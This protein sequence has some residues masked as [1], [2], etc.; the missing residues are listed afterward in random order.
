MADLCSVRVSG[1][2]WWMD[3]WMDEVQCST[4][5]AVSQSVSLSPEGSSLVNSMYVW[6]C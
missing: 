3:E 6:C 2:G 5:R 4:L 1:S